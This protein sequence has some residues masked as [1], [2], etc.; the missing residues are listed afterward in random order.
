LYTFIHNLSTVYQQSEMIST[1]QRGND[2][3]SAAYGGL[4][5]VYFLLAKGYTKPFSI[6][7]TQVSNYAKQLFCPAHPGAEGAGGGA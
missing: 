3:F 6:R 4:Q 1:Y 5:G 7:S 2:Y